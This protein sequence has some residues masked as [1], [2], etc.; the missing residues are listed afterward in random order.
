M[1]PKK[2]K[3]NPVAEAFRY[4]YKFFE[5]IFK[6]I[7]AILTQVGLWIKAVLIVVEKALKIIA[8]FLIT[9]SL[10]VLLFTT[11]LYVLSM[12]F[13]LKDSPAF[14]NLRDRMAELKVLK[15]EHDIRELEEEIMEEI[16][17]EEDEKPDEA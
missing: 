9:I 4:T 15:L 12:T 3:T 5:G 10:S 13:G 6:A 1:P 14:E 16:A 8:I 2:P 17:V 7:W 11:S